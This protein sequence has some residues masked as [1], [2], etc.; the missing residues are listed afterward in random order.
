[1]TQHR[2]AIALLLFACGGRAFAPVARRS[3]SFARPATVEEPRSLEDF[4][5]KVDALK[6][7][8]TRE[9]TSFFS[10]LEE[11][12][13]VPDV[14]FVDPLTKLDSLDAY[15]A[16]V[17]MLAGRTLMGR[18]LF[19]DAQIALHSVERTGARAM[20]TR[21]T[22]SFVFSALPWRPVAYF[23]GVS[24][25][26]I[27]DAARVVAQRDYWDSLGLPS[28][29][30]VAPGAAPD[31]Y[32][33]APKLESLA[34]LVA[35]LVPL[36]SSPAVTALSQ[37]AAG[38]ARVTYDLASAAPGR[39]FELLR[40]GSSYVVR[41]YSLAREGAEKPSPPPPGAVLT[42]EAAL[43]TSGSA[44]V[45]VARLD[46]GAEAATTA[47]TLRR[48]LAADGLVPVAGAELVVRADG[49]EAPGEIWVALE[50]GPW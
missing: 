17:D 6:A 49:E 45:A 31:T 39:A 32:A 35:Q 30:S 42:P 38:G 16:N 20:R 11:N 41:R 4:D 15:R 28:C 8:L 5:A 14:S 29:S 3:R 7:C 22:L 23:T 48:A 13:Y 19:S 47:A 46:V 40:R 44:V 50:P 26:E 25:Y 12:F 1:M 9:Y 2:L 36:E 24:E 10:P 21:W 43:A 18:V 37:V 34:D 33:P 27:D